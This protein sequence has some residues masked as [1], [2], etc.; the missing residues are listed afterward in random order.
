MKKVKRRAACALLL[1][2]AIIV[3][4]AVFLIRLADDGAA[5]AM[6]RAN[7]DVYQ[8]GV[9]NTG[10]LT[11]RN[12]VLLAQ[13]GDGIYRYADDA[14]VRTACLHAVGDYAGNIGTGAVTAFASRLAG[15]SFVNGLYSPDGTGATVELT[16]D[17]S[18]QATA[19]Q[20]LWGRKGAVLV[21]NYKTGEILC[22]VSAPSFD[23]NGTVDV[24][25][26][27]YEG[28]YLNRCLSSTFPPGSI[29]K[30]VTAAAAIE[31]IPDLRER[32]FTCQGQLEVDGETV[33]C[34]GWHGDQLFEDALANSCNCAFAQ[35]ALELGGETLAAYAEQFGLTSAQSLNG[36]PTAAGRFDVADTDRFDLA[37]SGMGQYNDLVNPYAFLRYICAIAGGGSLRE[38][39]LLL[40]HR[41]K[42]TSLLDEGTA[43]ELQQ[44]M[45]YT[46]FTAYGSSWRFPGLDICAKTGTAEVGDG[47]PHA[48]FAGFLRNEDHPLAFVVLVENGGGGL[49]AAG[50]LAGTVLQ[51]AVA[52]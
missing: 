16:I 4:M 40:G 44:L 24:N 8:N 23:P 38:P 48:W 35:I 39:T 46:A 33:V 36:I 47:S 52:G 18:L 12:G 6:F 49:D 27:G 3:G 43:Q 5:W 37:W 17:A 20:A 1:A 25:A 28:V 41:G 31:N 2:A 34:T 30:L 42:T 15:Y 45:N 11:D 21:C 14:A 29:F 9:L 7:P 50:T 19:Y 26:A 22:M 51:A 10:T 32:T 13:A